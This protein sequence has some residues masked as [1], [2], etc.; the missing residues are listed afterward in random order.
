MTGDR[1]NNPKGGKIQTASGLYHSLCT[2]SLLRHAFVK[3][4]DGENIIC[5]CT[6]QILVS[7]VRSMIVYPNHAYASYLKPYR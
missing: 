2:V 6:I 7:H 5:V 3:E 1:V 4:G